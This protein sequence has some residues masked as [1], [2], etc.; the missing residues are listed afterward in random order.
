MMPDAMRRLLRILTSVVTVL[1]LVLCVAAMAAWVR[2]YQVQDGVWWRDDQ[3]RLQGTTFR[4][5]LFI[6]FIFRSMDSWR[7]VDARWLEY[8][9]QSYAEAGLSDG[10]EFLNR[11]YF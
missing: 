10:D 2:S 8:A 3:R 11:F 9:P 4:G 7:P 1:S 6:E 5:G